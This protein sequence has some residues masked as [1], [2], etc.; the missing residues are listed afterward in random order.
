[1][2]WVLGQQLISP[3]IELHL[4][5]LD[6]AHVHFVVRNVDLRHDF[7]VTVAELGVDLR[8]LLLEKFSEDTVFCEDVLLNYLEIGLGLLQHGNLFKQELSKPYRC[9]SFQFLKFGLQFSHCFGIR[10][11]QIA[12][13][14]V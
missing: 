5:L 13:E 2:G 12:V 4:Q 6:F 14:V 3:Q 8:T 9:S 1:M 10:C 11:N 7:T